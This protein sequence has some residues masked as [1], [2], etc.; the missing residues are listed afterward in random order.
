MANF[1]R[2]DDSS[3]GEIRFI[4]GSPPRVLVQITMSD[5]PPRIVLLTTAQVQAALTGAEI[6]A[7]RATLPKLYAAAVTAAGGS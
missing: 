7:V 1:P 6:T 2:T 3:L 4:D 5:G